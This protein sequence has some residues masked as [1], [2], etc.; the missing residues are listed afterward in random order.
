MSENDQAWELFFKETNILTKL[1]SDNLAYITARELKHYGKREPR[2]M[3]KIDT[4]ALQP[5]IFSENQLS[6]LPVRNASY[7]IFK[8]KEQSS[9]YKFSK[10]DIDLP[11]IKHTPAVDVS[12]FDSFSTNLGLNESQALDF[13]LISSITHSFI[14]ER[15]IWL[16]IRGRQFSSKFDLLLPSINQTLTI[17]KV[18]IEIDA[19]YES[20]NA[21]YI[22][23]AK[24]SRRA[25]FNVRQLLYPYLDWKNRSKK[26]I[27]PIFFI[28]TNGLYYLYQFSMGN[29]LDSTKL[30]TK[31]CYTIDEYHYS[32]GDLW[33]IVNESSSQLKQVIGIPFPQA[34]DMDKVIDTVSLVYNG[35]NS[36]KSIAS[37]L[38]FDERQGDYYGNAAC[39]LGFLEHSQNLFTITPLGEKLVNEKFRSKRAII[40]FTALAQIKVFYNI[41]I[42]FLGRNMD[43]GTIDN[44]ELAAFI[45]EEH[46]LNDTTIFRRIST[47]KQWLIW[48]KNNLYLT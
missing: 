19:G 2:L 12:T 48:L 43:L 14:S 32:I 46:Q 25:D 3:A 27:V 44:N 7:A 41:L 1:D 34:D 47:V 15:D 28:Y 45:R 8:D 10:E 13:S 37:K 9:F 16:T 21:I 30:V 20:K 6:I 29:S 38:E 17:E 22:F 36:K 23:E 31:S 40:I 5:K 26:A 18:Q 39:Y 24:T 42:L 35:F 4:L 11:I 33:S